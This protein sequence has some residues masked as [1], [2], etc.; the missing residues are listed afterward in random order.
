MVVLKMLALILSLGMDT[1]MLSI[2]LGMVK[3]KG[4]LKVALT[5]A[6]AEA[7]MPLIGLFIGKGAGQFIGQSASLIGGVALLA[8]AVWL[9]FFEDEDEA[10]K[11][12]ERNLVGWTLVVT[13]LSISVDELAVGFSIGLVGVP[14]TLTI[15]LIALQAFIFTFIGLTFGSKLKPFLGEW[16]EKLAGI[17]LGLLGIWV[18]IG[19]FIHLLFLR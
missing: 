15:A 5:F 17:V 4:K 14:I 9:I 7:L 11:E 10:E 16:A 13:A 19:A 8:V 12:L 1:L 6:C 18:L 2:S 3:T